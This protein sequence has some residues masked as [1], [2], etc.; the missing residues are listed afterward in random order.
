MRI[1]T[2]RARRLRAQYVLQAQSLRSKLE[3]RVS[4]VPLA[5]RNK[6]MGDLLL[7]YAAMK[8]VD[9]QEQRV[10]MIK[11]TAPRKDQANQGKHIKPSTAPKSRGTKRKR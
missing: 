6:T 9:D 4:R 8:E 10:K 2:E 3:R 11:R 7:E 1:V 5:L